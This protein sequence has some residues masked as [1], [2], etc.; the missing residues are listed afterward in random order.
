MKLKL[1]NCPLYIF[2]I[3]L[4]FLQFFTFLYSQ[5]ADIENDVSDEYTTFSKN[6]IREVVQD[7]LVVTRRLSHFERMWPNMLKEMVT[8]YVGEMVDVE[9]YCKKSLDKIRASIRRGGRGEEL[10]CLHL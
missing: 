1:Y 5:D 10:G 8:K 9:A 7:A 6:Y 4:F 3:F 2:N